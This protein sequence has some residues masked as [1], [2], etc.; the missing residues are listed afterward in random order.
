[1]QSTSAELGKDSA[2]R[3][4]RQVTSETTEMASA[5]Q[6]ETTGQTLVNLE[7]AGSTG[8]SGT[9]QSSLSTTTTVFK[10]RDNYG[11]THFGFLTR[12]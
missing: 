1:M 5:S 2:Q 9:G 8:V 4:D 6:E 3:Q 11:L 10:V 12:D 7:T